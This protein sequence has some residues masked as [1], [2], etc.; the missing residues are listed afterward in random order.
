MG[1]HQGIACHFLTSFC[2]QPHSPSSTM[3]PPRAVVSGGRNTTP[4]R[5]VGNAPSTVSK[6]GDNCLSQMHNLNEG[7]W[8]ERRREASPGLE[9]EHVPFTVLGKVQHLPSFPSCSVQQG[10]AAMLPMR[11]SWDSRWKTRRV[12][13]QCSR[14]QLIWRWWGRLSDVRTGRS[15]RNGAV[16]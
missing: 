12:L 5:S 10:Y 15:R 9:H 8:R 14:K 7:Q 11:G 16:G 3:T 2:Q 6:T 4:A 13:L 1:G